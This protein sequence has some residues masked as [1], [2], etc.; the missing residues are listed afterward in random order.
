MS[1][2]ELEE[3]E[4]V[5]EALD[6]GVELPAACT[7][8][9]SCKDTCDNPPDVET[10]R[11]C[12]EF[13]EAAGLL[14]PGID[15][16][17]A[18]KMFQAI[19]AGRAPFKSPRDFKQCEDPP[20][21]EVFEKCISFAVEND[22][23]PPEEAE[24][25]KKTGGKGP[26]GCRG[27]E[28]CEV[29]CQ[30]HEEEC[31]RF[32]EE[33]DLISEED[34][35]RMREGMEEFRESLSD[36]PPEVADCLKE[37]LGS[38]MFDKVTSGER[39]P[40]KELGEKMRQ[41]FE[42]FFREGRDGF[43][44]GFGPG[45]GEEFVPP[46][47][48]GGP[49]GRGDSGPGGPGFPPEVRACLEEK[50]GADGFREISRSRGDPM[51]SSY[52]ATIEE[53]F[54]SMFGGGG[55]G[56]GGGKGLE[57]GMTPPGE[58][59]PE[60]LGEVERIRG[61]IFERSRGEIEERIRQGI[62]EGRDFGLEGFGGGA[63]PYQPPAG[64]DSSF[65]PGERGGFSPPPGFM[66]PPSGGFRMMPEGGYAPPPSG[67]S[68][69]PPAGYGAPPPDGL[70]PAGGGPSSFFF[71]PIGTSGFMASVISLFFGR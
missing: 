23:L 21:D 46:V 40:S 58:G 38:E 1:G 55:E 13:A 48:E 4:K 3:A 62:M 50:V 16:E 70:P 33:H 27:K 34:R 44:G 11:Q 20:N 43:E 69:A 52:R 15:R 6:S 60:V 68:Y 28:Q 39:P 61:E 47:L 2:E 45:G 63:Y 19:A 64:D 14:P 71:F 32:A 26:G 53:C 18:E 7:D 57:E 65:G 9:R 42:R 37:T 59:S 24:M 54:K 56:G 17:Q 31:F 10:A 36:A 8:E 22:L 66:M 25:I 29:Y 12:F 49:Q 35:E 41:C 67:G 5:L 51:R 30:E